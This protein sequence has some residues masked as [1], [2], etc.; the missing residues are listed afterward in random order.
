MAAI[1]RVAVVG[2]GTMGRQIALQIARGGVPVALYDVDSGAL[3]RAAAAQRDFVAGFVAG[4]TLAAEEAARVLA[5]IRYDADLGAATRDADLIIEAVPEQ[6]ALKRQVFAA[7]DEHAPDGAILATNS[8]SL[9]VSLLEDATARPERCANFHFY[10]PVWDNPMV[11]VGGGT[12]TDPAALDALDAFARRIGLLPLRVLRESTGFI[13][14]R[15]WRAIKKEVLAVADG[16][17]ASFEDIDRAWMLHYRT[18]KGPF[19]K[20]DEIGLDVVQA[21]EEV[22]AAESGDPADRP[23]PILTARVARGDLGQKSGRGFYAYPDPAW[24]A[25]DFLTPGAIPGA[26]PGNPG[27]T[28][29]DAPDGATTQH[30]DEEAR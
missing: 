11:E 14:N 28:P 25:P 16:G 13:F 24:A 30:D 21:I 6:V 2:S 8:S 20:M 29:A 18:P 10:L 27:A 19:G 4:G 22:Y 3:E 9:R 5:R 26:N 23:P 17:I 7:L 15:V 12:R 1:E